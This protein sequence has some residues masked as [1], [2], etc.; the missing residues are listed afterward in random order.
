MGPRPCTLPA[1]E[2]KQ[3]WYV[4]NNTNKCDILM[5]VHAEGERQEVSPLMLAVMNMCIVDNTMTLS[6]TTHGDVIISLGVA[7]PWRT[8]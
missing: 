4:A 6:T 8:C 7:R 3:Q 5:T 1:V 2:C